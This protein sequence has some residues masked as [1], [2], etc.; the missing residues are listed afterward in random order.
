MRR[1]RTRPRGRVAASGLRCNGRVMQPGIRR[2]ARATL[3]AFDRVDRL[4]HSVRTRRQ[5]LLEGFASAVLSSEELLSQ[6]TAVY[7]RR[8]EPSGA[9]HEWELEWLK[10]APP[11]PARVLVGGAGYGRECA[12]L[13]ARGYRVVAYEPSAEAA[14][15]CADHAPCVVGTH[16]DLTLAVERGAGPLAAMIDDEPFDVVWLGWGSLSHVLGRADRRRTLLASARLS[17]GP[18]F[19]SAW[20]SDMPRV[21]TTRVRWFLAGA[22]IGAALGGEA[23]DF[24]LTYGPQSGWAVVI[25]RAELEE[26]AVAM[27]RDL[28]VATHPGVSALMFRGRS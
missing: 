23:R 7:E 10:L 18:V 17:R 8:G 21:S 28:A 20:V 12:A 24:S 3:A 19:A 25:Q 9:L 11:P 14:E 22:R 26:C 5:G 2:L 15:A 1:D 4:A 27:D 16:E 6:T 13:A